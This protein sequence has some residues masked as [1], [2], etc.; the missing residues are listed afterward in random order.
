METLSIKKNLWKLYG[1]VEHPAEWDGIVFG[2]GKISQR[3]WEYFTAIEM[4]DLDKNAVVLD[5][6][7][8][9]GFFA[10][11]IAPFVKKVIILDKDQDPKISSFSGNITSVPHD[12]VGD[13]L[14]SLLKS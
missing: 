7:G 5:I 1:T 14:P 13:T 4:L 9:K 3:F 10:K 11:V 12:A 8:G 6:G 2:G